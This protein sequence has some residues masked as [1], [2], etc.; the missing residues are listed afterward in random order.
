[1]ALPSTQNTLQVFALGGTIDKIYFDALSEYQVGKPQVGTIFQ[2]AGL[3]LQYD[4]QSICSKDS[5]D[6]TDEDRSALLN[7]IAAT[8][9]EQILITH[10]TDTMTTTAQ[11]LKSNAD[12][13]LTNKTIVF[14]GA[15]NPA[16]FKLSDAPFNV[17][18][19][20]GA[21]RASKPGIYIAMN[22]SIFNPDEV[23]KNRAAAQFQATS[24]SDAN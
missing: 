8:E 15:M 3:A 7:A 17:G 2:D 14:V 23:K 21:L 9:H 22:G 6:I 11:Y 20:L 24:S 19:A 5:L 10:G 16:C 12:P 13:A 18:F 1:M 4:I